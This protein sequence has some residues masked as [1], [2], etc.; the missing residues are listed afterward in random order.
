MSRLQTLAIP[1]LTPMILGNDFLLEENQQKTLAAW[2]AMHCMVHEQSAEELVSISELERA[3]LMSNQIPPGNWKIWIARNENCSEGEWWHFPSSLEI[4]FFSA[5]FDGLPICDTAI[6]TGTIGHFLFHV[7]RTTT[8]HAPRFIQEPDYSS[9]RHLKQIHPLIKSVYSSEE[10]P[11]LTSD[12]VSF[13]A[14]SLSQTIKQHID[15]HYR[16][17]HNL[18]NQENID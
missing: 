5:D 1:I 10:L 15:Y 3:F 6:F 12:E 18:L 16:F 2:I 9:K 8:D 4:N 11:K 13:I 14:T 7:F 17:Y